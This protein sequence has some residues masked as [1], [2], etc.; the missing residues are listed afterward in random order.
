M[1]GATLLGG[2]GSLMRFLAPWLVLPCTACTMVGCS[3]EGRVSSGDRQNFRLQPTPEQLA[4]IEDA[5]EP[6]ISPRTRFAAARF[7]ESTRQFDKAVEQYTRAIADDPHFVD[8]HARLGIVR[9]LFG[10]H[11]E[12]EEALRKA[13]ELRPDDA[14]LWNNL[15]FE[16]IQQRR[17]SEAERGL[18]HALT[19]DPTLPNARTNLALALSAQARFKE[20]L[21]EY[22]QVLPETDAYYNIGLAYRG[23]KRYDEARA[24]FR[25]VLTLNPNFQAA[26]KQLAKLGRNERESAQAG[27]SESG[28]MGADTEQTKPAAAAFA[29]RQRPDGGTQQHPTSLREQ[30]EAPPLGEPEEH[31]QDA[32]G[33]AAVT[34]SAACL[35][36]APSRLLGKRVS[37][38]AHIKSPPK[39]RGAGN[40]KPQ[41]QGPSPPD[42][43]GEPE[44]PRRNPVLATTSVPEPAGATVIPAGTERGDANVA[45]PARGDI[46]G[47]SLP[48]RCLS[49]FGFLECSRCDRDGDGDIDLLDYGCLQTARSRP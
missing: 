33:G 17:W 27:G 36:D 46:H 11:R 39:A 4:S 34:E 35:L 18:R 23:Q 44:V 45:P 32:L 29:G 2:K 48:R 49:P 41:G 8:A 42:I 47:E 25:H 5:P 15:A 3:L 21:A 22:K 6:R 43:V 1:V 40:E 30:P 14:V 13:V 37:V 16:F 20:A 9:G 7:F 12:A 19:L 10:Q 31:E 24:T 26:H 38:A 28:M